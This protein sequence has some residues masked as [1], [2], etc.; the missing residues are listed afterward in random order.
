MMAYLMVTFVTGK[1]KTAHAQRHILC[2]S[3][4]RFPHAR[5][6]IVIVEP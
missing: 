5:T 4:P 2:F 6:P 1:H 3:R